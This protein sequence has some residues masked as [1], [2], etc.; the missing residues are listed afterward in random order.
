MNQNQRTI[1]I[2]TNKVKWAIFIKPS[3]KQLEN[4]RIEYRFHPLDI[5]DCLSPAQR[6][7]LDEY[8]QYLFL[9]LTFPYYESEDRFIK[10][11]EVNFFIGPDY[12]I[13]I[14]DGQLMPL[15]KF[16]EQCQINDTL[17]EKFM[18]ESP[19]YLLYEI[20]NRL[21][22]YC[23][24]ML[25]HINSDIDAIQKVIFEGNEKKMVK[26][27]LIIKRNIVSLRK[28]MQA[29]KNIVRKLINQ[30][31]KYFIPSAMNVYFNNTLEQTKDIWDILETLNE[32]INA[33][34]ATNESLISFRLND[35]MKMLTM[36]MVVLLPINLVASIFGM[37]TAIT[38]I[39]QHP[40]GFWMI[41]G[42]MALLIVFIVTFFK[43]KKWF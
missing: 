1:E 4:L 12:L 27:I 11:S 6:P 43:K 10:A 26:E 3:A 36:I 23:Y 7:K 21:Q 15:L 19:T 9:I 40:L 41:L 18:N 38:P 14:T 22:L 37:N 28:I 31:D 17:R 16:F 42:L 8:D 24:P 13:T 25:D 35:V 33:L 34:H 2:K 39:V 29:H 5:D 32:T 30:K 20:I